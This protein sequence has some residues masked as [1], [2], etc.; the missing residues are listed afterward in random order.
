MLLSAPAQPSSAWYVSAGHWFRAYANAF[1]SSECRD[2]VFIFSRSQL[3]EFQQRFRFQ[4]TFRQGAAPP[5]FPL[6]LPRWRTVRRSVSALHSV[7]TDGVRM[8]IVDFTA[9]GRLTGGFRYPAIPVQLVEP[10]VCIRLQG[11]TTEPARWVCPDGC[12]SVRASKP[13]HPAPALTSVTVVTNVGSITARS[14]FLAAAAA[15]GTRRVI[16]V[17]SLPSVSSMVLKRFF[18][19]DS[20]RQHASASPTAV[21]DSAPRHGGRTHFRLASAGGVC[22]ACVLRSARGR[23]PRSPIPARWAVKARGLRDG[24]ALEYRHAFHVQPG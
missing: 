4:L 6:S 15:A 14:S 19:G 5:S 1:A 12:L 13:N 3:S 9:G 8:H 16:S 18:S 20:S 23:Q 10:G 17:W 2:R 24:I 7:R 21:N 11:L 22:S